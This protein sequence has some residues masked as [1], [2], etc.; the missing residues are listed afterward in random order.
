MNPQYYHERGSRSHS[1]RSTVRE[2]VNEASLAEYRLHIERK[3]ICL[4]LK[5]NAVG[6]FVRITET[7]RG[8][9]NSIIVPASGLVELKQAFEKLLMALGTEPPL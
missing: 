9:R 3:E 7:S 8:R 6:K 4:S 5:E 2:P 1:V